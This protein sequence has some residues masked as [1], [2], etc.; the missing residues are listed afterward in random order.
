MLAQLFADTVYGHNVAVK[1][2]VGGLGVKHQTG[3]IQ[4]AVLVL[5]KQTLCDVFNGRC[6]REHL[7]LFQPLAYLVLVEIAF[8]QVGVAAQ[9]LC[10]LLRGGCHQAVFHVERHAK[11]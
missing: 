4:S 7:K 3:G 8:C 10:Q 5:G 6:L 11:P 2:Y 9:H 1:T